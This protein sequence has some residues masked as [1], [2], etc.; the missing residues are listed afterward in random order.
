MYQFETLIP[1]KAPIGRSRFRAEQKTCRKK[2]VLSSLGNRA[3]RAKK[4]KMHIL[5][6]KRDKEQKERDENK[7]RIILDVNERNPQVHLCASPKRP[8]VSEK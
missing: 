6:L 3:Y 5:E 2:K 7:Y 1:Q 4:A 8:V